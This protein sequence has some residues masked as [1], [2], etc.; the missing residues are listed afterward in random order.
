M[1]VLFTSGEFLQRQG[2]ALDRLRRETGVELECIGVPEEGPLDPAQTE[3]VEIAFL[4]AD[5][6]VTGLIRPF[7]GVARRAPKLRWMQVAHAGTDAPIYAEL[8]GRGVR[9]TTSSGDNSEPIAHTAIAGLLMLARGFPR[10]LEAQRR[11]AWEQHAPEATPRDLPGQTMLLVGVGAIGNEIGRLT[12]ALG[13]HVIGVR[14]SP[15]RDDDHVDEMQPPAALPELYPRADWLVI[16]CPLTE[17]TR[18][19]VDAE[20]IRRLPRGAHVINVARGQIV[21]EEAMTEALRS[22]HLAGAYLDVFQEEPLPS[23]SPLWDL[24]N[25]I[26]TPHNSSAATG[27]LERTDRRFLANLERWMR[28]QPLDQEVT[29]E[30]RGTA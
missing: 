1:V 20:A 13:L 14:R 7:F 8:M 29:P 21:D 11:H 27:N 24:P 12:R 17:E 25:V 5:L 15:Q 2:E 30:V 28:G 18:G 3:R 26:V 23:E 10:W 22:G 19:L 6:F 16:A 4:A 9:I